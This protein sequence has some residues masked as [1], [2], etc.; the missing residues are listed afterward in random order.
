LESV[1]TYLM[2]SCRYTLDIRE[3][4]KGKDPVNFYKQMNDGKLKTKMKYSE[5]CSPNIYYALWINDLKNMDIDFYKKL[6]F[7]FK[8][9]DKLWKIIQN[10]FSE[11]IKSAVKIGKM[12]RGE[13]IRDY[14]NSSRVSIML[15]MLPNQTLRLFSNLYSIGTFFDISHILGGR[16]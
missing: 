6:K 16:K 9:V 11:D 5:G 13:F 1:L 2:T 14:T 12:D 3:L 4:L 8:D 15:W 10:R 7:E